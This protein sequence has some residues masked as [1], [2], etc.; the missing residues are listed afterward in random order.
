MVYNR[1]HK[2][3]SKKIAKLK[4]FDDYELTLG[5]IM[6]GERATMG[7]SLLDVQRELHINPRYI[8]A[9]ETSN[10]SEFESMSFVSGY[11]KSYARYLSLNPEEAYQRFCQESGFI[12]IHAEQSPHSVV[13]R[14]AALIAEKATGKFLHRKNHRMP[15]KFP[16]GKTKEDGFQIS[17]RGL[18]SILILTC[19]ILGIGYGGWLVLQE[20]QRVQVVPAEQV[21]FVLLDI[22]SSNPEAKT[23]VSDVTK[24]TLEAFDR[25]RRPQVLDFPRVVARDGPISTLD[26]D[27]IGVFAELSQSPAVETTALTEE[28]QKP[29]ENQPNVILPKP[30][31]P[32][33]LVA[34]RPAWVRISSAAGEKLF[35]G[36]LE[37]GER[38]VVP[39]EIAPP[40]VR[41]GESG[42]I[43]FEI[44]GQYYGPVGKRGAVTPNVILSADEITQSLTL[45]D[46][47]ADVD[48]KKLVD[49]QQSQAVSSSESISNASTE[50]NQDSAVLPSSSLVSAEIS[51]PLPQVV[52]D[53]EPKLRLV[54]VRP[55]WVRVKASDGSIVFEGTLDSGETYRVPAIEDPLT[56]RVGDSGATYFSIGDKFYGPVGLNGKVTSNVILSVQSVKTNMAVADLKNDEDLARL[57]AEAQVVESVR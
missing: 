56:L 2:S 8:E 31:S 23:D 27:H 50:F 5:D 7:K 32:L 45:A 57:V 24:P 3:L 53:K 16:I 19:L 9:I 30:P 10:L 35:E 4:G 54:A 33:Q 41:V 37:P 42:S 18:G 43:Y 52:E 11:V 34:V 38:Y 22:D 14:G 55:T 51:K 28:V 15:N 48:L 47:N 13:E 39:V 49:I 36:I 40:I 6:R 46:F 12:P 25:L 44:G 1:K 26:P 21:P 17:S 20:V 29:D